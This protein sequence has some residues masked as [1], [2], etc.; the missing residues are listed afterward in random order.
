M[1]HWLLGIYYARLRRLDIEILW[2]ECRNN[3]KD[4]DK[5]RAAFL[6]HAYHDPAW[7][8]IGDDEIY[9]IINNLK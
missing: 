2:P 1:I 4:I 3:A 6:V 9:K 7:V 5:A 8:F